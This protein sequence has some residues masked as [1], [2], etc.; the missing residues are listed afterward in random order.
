M[1]EFLTM[2]LNYDS[3]CDYMDRRLN[4]VWFTYELKDMCK[5]S[6]R[7][8]IKDIRSNKFEKA[9]TYELMDLNEV[10][11]TMHLDCDCSAMCKNIIDYGFDGEGR[12][13]VEWHLIF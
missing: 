13:G 5:D 10:V 2:K 6:A 12:W 4:T 1:S 11:Y 9:P 8:I 3:V 7:L